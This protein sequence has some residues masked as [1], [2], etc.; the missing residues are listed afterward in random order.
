[1]TSRFPTAQEFASFPPPNYVDPETKTAQ[2]LGILI[3]MTVLVIVFILARI[4]SRTIIVLAIGMDDW[5]MLVAAVS[6]DD[7]GTPTSVLLTRNVDSP[8]RKQ[9]HGV[10]IDECKLSDRLS[11]V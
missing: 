3:P 5:L 9:Y 7:T 2:V 6:L 11:L 8:S 4:W 1:M 10:Y